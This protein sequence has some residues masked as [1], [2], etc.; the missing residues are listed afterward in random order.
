VIDQI[1]QMQLK[2][3][4]VSNSDEELNNEIRKATK[5]DNR[6]PK[7]EIEAD[8]YIPTVGHI[9]LVFK[10]VSNLSVVPQNLPDLHSSVGV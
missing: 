9:P 10:K 7:I 3:I 4:T 8:G 5:D 1:K 6:Y 2:M